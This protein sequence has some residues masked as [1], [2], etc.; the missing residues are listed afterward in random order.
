[1][2]LLCFISSLYMD[3]IFKF[4]KE[5]TVMMKRSTPNL[6]FIKNVQCDIYIKIRSTGILQKI[7]REKQLLLNQKLYA[8]EIGQIFRFQF[9]KEVSFTF[10]PCTLK[11][12]FETIKKHL[13][14]VYLHCMDRVLLFLFRVL[15]DHMIFKYC[16]SY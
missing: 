10:F 4:D 3:S 9:I 11:S 1:M 12:Y 5:L 2:H 16:K 6:I 14:L 8:Y 15:S 7:T 13:S